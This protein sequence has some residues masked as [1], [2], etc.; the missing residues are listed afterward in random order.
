MLFLEVR[1]STAKQFTAAPK[2]TKHGDN[3]GNGLTIVDNIAKKYSGS[4]R[5]TADG[6]EACAAFTAQLPEVA[7]P[8]FQ[9]AD[10]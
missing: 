5:I 4:F 2:S 6:R 8:Q 10:P 3:H 7:E 9:P 1:N